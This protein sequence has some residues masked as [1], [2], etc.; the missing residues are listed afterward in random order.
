[1]TEAD[2]LS[3]MLPLLKDRGSRIEKIHGNLFQ[4]GLPDWLLIRPG[5]FAFCELK[6]MSQ[7]NPNLAQ[8]QD[9]LRPEQKKNV[10]IWAHQYHCPVY[11][12]SWTPIGPVCLHG[13]ELP[14]LL[15][16]ALPAPLADFVMTLE[17]IADVLSG[18]SEE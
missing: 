17:E 10:A 2:F 15:Q 18:R 4:S 9:K 11:V 3:T 7:K 16:R 14:P 13:R 6:T 8:L 5:S 1:M 12:A